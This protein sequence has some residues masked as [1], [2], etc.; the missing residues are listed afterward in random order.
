MGNLSSRRQ[1]QCHFR[2]R[3]FLRS[4][5]Q[6]SGSVHPARRLHGDL[7]ARDPGGRGEL[8]GLV[9]HAPGR[10]PADDHRVR[11]CGNDPQR[12]LGGLAERFRRA[13]LLQRAERRH[14]DER[15]RADPGGSLA[16]VHGRRALSPR[17]LRA[18]APPESVRAP[19]GRAGAVGLSRAR[20]S[21]WEG[22]PTLNYWDKDLDEASGRGAVSGLSSVVRLL[23]G[24][25]TISSGYLKGVDGHSARAL[26]PSANPAALSPHSAVPCLRAAG[27]RG[28]AFGT[29]RPDILFSHYEVRLRRR[30]STLRCPRIRWRDAGR[31]ELVLRAAPGTG[32]FL[33]KAP[34]SELDNCQTGFLPR[35]SAPSRGRGG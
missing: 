24:Q 4:L 8:P 18:S 30:R 17:R 22:R 9:H 13:R 28:G 14:A 21:A 1:A 26:S 33:S 32:T 34:A 19:I 12:A 31:P 25:A 5:R 27:G 20:R 15:V 6:L 23:H 11:A 35:R 7:E 29:I 3:K 16:R 2:K 10:K